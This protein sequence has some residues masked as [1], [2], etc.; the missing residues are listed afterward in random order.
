MK[1]ALVLTVS[2]FALATALATNSTA[3]L[4]AAPSH[5][6]GFY[7]AQKATGFLARIDRG[8]AFIATQQGDE[9][10]IYASSLPPDV[11]NAL[12]DGQKVEF[13]VDDDP[14]GRGRRAVN[15]RL[16]NR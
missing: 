6:S 12:L 9:V 7:R 4:A 1:R 8:L 3:A 10:F 11:L 13:D 2:A 14:G 16:A 15:V 5:E